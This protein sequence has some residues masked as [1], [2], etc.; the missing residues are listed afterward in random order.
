MP[1]ITVLITQ[2][3]LFGPDPK[4]REFSKR[5]FCF[6]GVL[7]FRVM[8]DETTKNG[9]GPDDLPGGS[10]GGH[11]LIGKVLDGRYRIDRVLGSGAIG[12]VFSAEDL[13]DGGKV[14]IKVLSDEW[15][16]GTLAKSRFEREGMAL[17]KLE[18]P[19]IVHIINYGV[20][21]EVP[22]IA[23]EALQGISLKELLSEGKPL[24]PELALSIARQ[25]LSALA[26]AHKKQIVHRDLK[27]A[28]VLLEP[29]ENDE[30]DVKL[31]DFGLAKFM[32]PDED[33]RDAD[34][35]A[36]T[37]TKTGVVVGTPLYMAPEQAIGGKVD[38]QTDVYAAGVV[39]F[40]MLTGRPPFEMD[41]HQELVKAHLLSPVPLVSD[42]L[43][44]SSVDPALDAIVEKAMAKQAKDRFEDAAQMLE[45]L[46]KATLSS[47]GR[48]FRRIAKR[49]K[50]VRKRSGI[51]WVGAAAT[52]LVVVAVIGFQGYGKKPVA[53]KAPTD[54]WS[55]P[56]T[57]EALKP[58]YDK[59]SRGESTTEAEE[60]LLLA[61]ARDNPRD[62]RADLLLGH[63]YAN[64]LWR[65]DAITRY[66]RAYRIEPGARADPS[67]LANLLD[68]T[69]SNKQGDDACAAIE[70]IFSAE[71]LQAVEKALK[72]A[73]PETPH[74]Q[75]LLQLRDKISSK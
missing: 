66:L 24:K 72:D 56:G 4:T 70:E 17:A 20:D 73:K 40:E 62:P 21:G 1:D 58:I 34:G 11:P 23:M 13:S 35:A 54:P 43:S 18:H 22:Y 32:A 50:S 29:A 16:I 26:Y 61:Y 25:I 14:A 49:I 12:V 68:F 5:A 38:T 33:G 37:L 41:S 36:Q 65:R 19:N 52:F 7:Y 42:A 9:W 31:L 57:P 64:K 75:R 30:Y 46:N 63:G 55:E 74:A 53:E 6:D 44:G 15:Y 28:N 45:A 48:A 3:F 51:L 47:K 8:N 60:K 39:L 10:P 71:A 67:M 59:V 69:S 2:I 27:P